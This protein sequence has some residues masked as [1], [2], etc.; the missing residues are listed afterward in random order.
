MKGDF[1]RE[2]FDRREHYTRVLLQQ[3]RALLDA[4]WN[5]QAAITRHHVRTLAV[6]LIGPHGG[7]ADCC[8]FEVISDPAVVE[9]LTD[10]LGRPLRRERVR[11]L[12][13]K[14]EGGDFLIGQGR[15]YVEGNLAECDSWMAYSEQ[16]GYPFDDTTTVEALAGARGVL[17][18]LDVWERHV[19][20]AERPEMREVALGGPDTTT[21]AALVWQVKILRGRRPL[22]CADA[23]GLA[24]QRPPLLRARAHRPEGKPR[25]G[26]MDQPAPGYRGT[27]NR[28]YRIEI[29]RG[30]RAVSAGTGSEVATFSWSRDNGSV[31]FPVLHHS[32][33]DGKVV[34]RLGGLGQDTRG[35]LTPGGWVQ[36]VDD[37]S[38]LR[39]AGSPVLSI[40]SVDLSEAIV[41]LTGAADGT[42]SD[43]GLHPVLRRWDHDAGVPSVSDAGALLVREA[44]TADDGWIELEDGVM[45]QFPAPS[46][47]QPHNDYRTGDYWLVPA[48]TS[49]RDVIWPTETVDDR[50]A[51]RPRTPDGIGHSFAPLAVAS[52][53][54]DGR[55]TVGTD[56]RRQLGY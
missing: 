49:T 30:G 29:Q 46:P 31:V 11:E 15:Y 12:R 34:L 38:T 44:M 40:D 33:T 55:W 24:R 20:A 36:L 9:T 52:L 18:Y 7:P 23:V 2:T 10:D 3:G 35:G 51:A 14:I 53:R 25:D 13:A 27:E 21:R 28:L 37:A 4:D 17:V 42:G 39:G 22:S 45:V 47:G 1:S 43:P 16:P 6:D 54:D 41:V 32:Q 26:V 56:C 19:A 8:G 48:R 5:E 50:Q